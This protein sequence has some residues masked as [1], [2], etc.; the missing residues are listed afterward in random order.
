[1]T[2][3]QPCN[4][5]NVDPQCYWCLLN[6]DHPWHD[7]GKPGPNLTDYYKDSRNGTPEFYLEKNGYQ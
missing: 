3:F 1:M 7:N 2:D 6:V 5:Q 4:Y